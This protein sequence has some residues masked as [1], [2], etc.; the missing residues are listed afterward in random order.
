MDKKFRVCLWMFLLA[1]WLPGYSQSSNVPH[2]RDYY[3]LLD[4]YEIKSGQL[5]TQIHTS[6]KPVQAKNVA[7]FAKAISDSLSRPSGRDTFNLQYL[8]RD[9]WEWRQDSRA[10]PNNGLSFLHP[11]IP[12]V[13]SLNTPALK[14]HINPVLELQSGKEQLDRK[15]YHI[16]LGAEV[17]GSIYRKLG[18]YAM[19][20]RN[21]ARFPAYVYS[22]IFAQQVVPGERYWEGNSGD[23]LN[24]RTA[25]AH[26]SLNATR[27]INFQFGQDRFFIGNGHRSMILSDFGTSYPFLKIQTQVWRFSY[28]NLFA[29]LR[30]HFPGEG[31][32]AR[33]DYFAKKFFALHHLS[34][35]ITD[36]LNIGLFEAIVSG[37]SIL[38]GF[39]LEYLNPVIFYRAVEH[40]VNNSSTGNALLGMDAKW[41]FASI[42]SYTGSLCWTN[43]CYNTCG[44][45]KAGGPTNGLRS[46]GSNM[47]MCCISKTSTCSSSGTGPGHLCMRIE[48]IIPA[49][50]I[51]RSRWPTLWGR[52]STSS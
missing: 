40:N 18:F 32:A 11:E 52:T 26:L 47:W 4:R 6:F 3:H 15:P 41:N 51:I 35:N 30:G 20:S 36:N 46:W 28:T 5:S 7:E 12:D 44:K 24:F 9:N 31:Y 45:R 8:A 34:L 16:G 50:P 48:R 38:G 23:Q 10:D 1:A 13:F 29:D 21:Q 25:R 22:R 2:S 14:L 42:F 27:H 33:R 49:T 19:F 39:A 17:S 43:F 37:D